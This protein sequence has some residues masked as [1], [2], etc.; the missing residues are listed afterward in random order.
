MFLER[1]SNEKDK[2]SIDDF[3]LLLWIDHLERKHSSLSLFL[4]WEE[5]AVSRNALTVFTYSITIFI[6]CA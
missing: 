2:S 3:P 1:V 4:S 5:A 6:Y